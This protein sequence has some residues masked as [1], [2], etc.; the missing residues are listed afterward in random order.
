MGNKSYPGQAQDRLNRYS[1]T[2]L[3][4]WGGQV[5]HQSPFVYNKVK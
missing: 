4:C 1:G 3:T 5:S 2:R